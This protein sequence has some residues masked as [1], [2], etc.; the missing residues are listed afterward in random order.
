MQK[1]I[2]FIRLLF[3]FYLL[4]EIIVQNDDYNSSN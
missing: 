1:M 2:L 3:G 4:W